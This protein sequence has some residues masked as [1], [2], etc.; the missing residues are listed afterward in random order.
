[1]SHTMEKKERKKDRN[2]YFKGEA[3]VTVLLCSNALGRT[4]LKISLWF[5]AE[6]E[7]LARP[8]WLASLCTWQAGRCSG[9]AAEGCTAKGPG[10]DW[11]HKR[12]PSQCIIAITSRLAVRRKGLDPGLFFF[13]FSS[14]V[15]VKCM[16]KSNNENS[17]CH[18]FADGIRSWGVGGIKSQTPHYMNTTLILEEIRSESKREC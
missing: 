16:C 11:N 12:A 4:A 7:P 9:W 13:F 6:T 15:T 8:G 5:S 3:V 1:M 17:E 2:S 18:V 10:C 14:P